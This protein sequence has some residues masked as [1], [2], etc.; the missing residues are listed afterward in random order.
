MKQLITVST[1]K[2]EEFV[3]KSTFKFYL[4]G[5]RCLEVIKSGST[6]KTLLPLRRVSVGQLRELRSN[7]NNVVFVL[8]QNGFLY[9]ADIS[10]F[11]NYLTLAY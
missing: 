5:N 4:T 10:A 2:K 1:A 9:Y 3:I 7:P 11:K 8:K 6:E